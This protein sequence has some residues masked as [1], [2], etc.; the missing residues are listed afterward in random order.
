[1]ADTPSVPVDDMTLRRQLSENIDHASRDVRVTAALKR[2]LHAAFAAYEEDKVELG[3]RPPSTKSLKGLLKF[4]SHPFRSEWI[5][6]SLAINPDGN[7]VAIWDVV[8]NRYSVEFFE[9]NSADWIGVTRS[10]DY[11]TPSRGHYDNFDEWREP[12]FLIPKRGDY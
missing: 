4:L 11:V 2:A 9:I 3:L 6:P 10:Y 5:A 7:F 12:P 1:M 8:P